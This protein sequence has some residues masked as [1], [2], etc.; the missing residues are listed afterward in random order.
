AMAAAVVG[1]DA[2]PLG[3][4][5]EHLRIPIVAAERPPMVEDDRR[6]ALGTPV[7]VI[8]FRAVFGDDRTHCLAPLLYVR[9]VP[10]RPASMQ[11]I[12]VVTL[13]AVRNVRLRCRTINDEPCRSSG[14]SG[15]LLRPDKGSTGVLLGPVEREIR[16][17]LPARLKTG[18]VRAVGIDLEFGF[19]R[20]L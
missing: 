6:G 14:R 4:E 16:D 9:G 11:S 3:E 15:G 10:A 5:I 17:L 2:I 20:R 12:R 19:R 7:L 13:E 18:P 8:D 1:D